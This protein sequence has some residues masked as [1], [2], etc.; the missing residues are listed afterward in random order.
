[1]KMMK[2]VNTLLKSRSMLITW[3]LYSALAAGS[4][5]ADSPG[6]P[7]QSSGKANPLKNV[8]FGEQHLH[9]A[10]SPDAFAMGTRNTPD[11]AYRFCKAEAIKKL[12]DGT[13]VQKKTPY[14]WCAVTDYAEFLGMLP[15]MIDKTNPLADTQIGKLI[16]SGDPKD[17]AEAFQIIISSVSAGKPPSYLM[18]PKTMSSVWE[19]QK[20]VANKHNDPGVFTTL[21]AFEWTIDPD[22]PE[23]SPQCVLPRRQGAGVGLLVTRFRKAGRPV[24][25]PGSAT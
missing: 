5:A 14:D 24:D 3:T 10:N 2:N 25:L 20:A 15:L 21:I 13:T 22:G 19:T 23:S 18:D 7:G 4:A 8:Y 12:V 1:M 9:T 17:G 16:N 11:D 6:E